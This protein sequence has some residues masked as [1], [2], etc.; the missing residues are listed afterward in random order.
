MRRLAIIAAA[1]AC[2]CSAEVISIDLPAPD[3]MKAMLVGYHYDNETRMVG[4]DLEQPIDPGLLPNVADFTDKATVWALF[5]DQT[6][7]EVHLAPGEI[8]EE[9]EVTAQ[10]RLEDF[11]QGYVRI[12]P[13]EGAWRGQDEGGPRVGADV[14]FW[15]TKPPV[16][17]DHCPVEWEVTAYRIPGEETF[18][19]A[20][21]LSDTRVIAFG[22]AGTI[23]DI[24]PD[25]PVPYARTSTAPIPVPL[26]AA[27]APNGELWMGAGTGTVSGVLFRGRMDSGFELVAEFP[28]A[29]KRLATPDDGST[30]ELFGTTARGQIIR[31]IDGEL[32][33]YDF[34]GG[35]VRA[36]DSGV[37]WRSE[38]DAALFLNDNFYSVRNGRPSRLF[39]NETNLGGFS[40]VT[41]LADERIVA[42]VKRGAI[43]TPEP[44]DEP[45]GLTK[46]GTHTTLQDVTTMIPY[47]RGFLYAPI[48]LAL[49]YGE[50]GEPAMCEPEEQNFA[51]FTARTM[52]RMGEHFVVFGSVDPRSGTVDK[53][54]V[55]LVGRATFPEP[56]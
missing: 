11:T 19:A 52:N 29:V 33:T 6:L 44:P 55:I 41:K 10:K 50:L 4:F 42:L 26:S 37:V 9:T 23:L 28:A 17:R 21:T 34:S 48:G 38:D 39:T 12:V 49:V 18:Y 43:L 16:N 45:T 14:G 56:N 7:E 24:S 35:D 25:G 47:H 20:V 2:A 30:D 22:D 1:S 15:V 5:Y 53:R 32:D 54:P 8:L 13:D 40:A 36:S 3:G 46:F 31:V 27:L 51:D